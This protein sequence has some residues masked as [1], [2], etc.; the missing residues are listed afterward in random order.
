MKRIVLL[1]ALIL[2]L[3]VSASAQVVYKCTGDRVRVRTAPNMNSSQKQYDYDGGR[4]LEGAISLY[5]GELLESTGK[6]RNGFIEVS[7][8]N[9]VGCG[10]YGT[11]W[12]SAK[13]LVKV[14]PCSKCSGFGWLG[15]V[16]GPKETCP[17]CKG[18]G[19]R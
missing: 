7:P 6:Q 16:G 10:W 17:V 4:G 1:F 5:K 9:Y 18:K 19:H 3:G 15:I 2:T 13:Y 8:I 12:V 14:K 11:G